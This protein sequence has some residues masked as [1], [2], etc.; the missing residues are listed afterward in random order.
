MDKSTRILIGIFCSL[1]LC[2]LLVSNVYSCFQGDELLHIESGNHLAWGYMEYPPMIGFLTF[3][4][5][6]L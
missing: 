4:Q 5:N 3:L 1:K 6:I 2:F